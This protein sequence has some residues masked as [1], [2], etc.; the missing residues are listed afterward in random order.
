MTIAAAL[1]TDL[2]ISYSKSIKLSIVRTSFLVILSPLSAGFF[3]LICVYWLILLVIWKDE[4]NGLITTI[5]SN[6]YLKLSKINLQTK[7]LRRF[8]NERRINSFALTGFSQELH[9]SIGEGFENVFLQ[10]CLIHLKMP[11]LFKRP[12]VC[13]TPISVKS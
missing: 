7:G 12:F 9:K 8:D 5:N 4:K 2:F 3:A 10:I 13:L 1:K 6:Y 11:V